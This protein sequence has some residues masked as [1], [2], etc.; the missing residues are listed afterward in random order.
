M[1]S[2]PKKMTA[3]DLAGLP[4]E[5]LLEAVQRQTFRFFWEGAELVSGMAR[6][7]PP[8]QPTLPTISPRSGA[9]ASA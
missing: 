2:K 7:A 5:A 1:A 8:P 4:D 6:D 3:R 9:P